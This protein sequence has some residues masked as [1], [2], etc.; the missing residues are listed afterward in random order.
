MTDTVNSIT[1][2]KLHI[3]KTVDS[4]L[5]VAWGIPNLGAIFMNVLTLSC[6]IKIPWCVHL[7]ILFPVLVD[8]NLPL[9][10]STYFTLGNWFIPAD[11]SKKAC[12]FC[13]SM[14]ALWL[15]IVK[16]CLN[17]FLRCHTYTR[18]YIYIYILKNK[19]QYSN[20]NL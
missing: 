4:I 12:F 11:P 2:P 9:H 17:F 10:V 14:E 20:F 5:I 13:K 7:Q 19:T 8:T 15:C 16:N 6:S 18:A 3:Q 1:L